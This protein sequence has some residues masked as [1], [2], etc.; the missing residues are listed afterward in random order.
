MKITLET[1]KDHCKQVAHHHFNVV[2]EDVTL[3]PLGAGLGFMSDAYFATISSGPKNI[4]MFVKVPPQDDP[5]K[6]ELWSC[7]EQVQLFDRE[8][9]VYNNL[10]DEFKEFILSAGEDPKRFLDIFPE[11]YSL[12]G[13]MNI[14]RALK[15][16]IVLED[17]GDKGYTM[18]KDDVAGLDLE[19]TFK[20]MEG[21]GKYHGLTMAFLNG[22]GIKDETTKIL[23]DYDMEKM[24]TAGSQDIA[25]KGME[26]FELWL[27]NNN[28]D[29]RNAEKARLLRKDNTWKKMA[30]EIFE[31]KESFPYNVLSHGDCRSNNFMFSYTD[32]SKK[33]LDV[34]FCDHQCGNKI[35]LFYDLSYF[36]LTTPASKD[37]MENYDAIMQKYHSS[38]VDSLTRL[39][40]NKNMPS[41]DE[42]KSILETNF[43]FGY[44]INLVLLFV[45]GYSEEEKNAKCQSLLDLG[46][47]L[48]VFV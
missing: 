4:N 42:I 32:D 2:A 41:L 39:K 6:L 25:N 16:P 8:F 45:N 12:P 28:E 23:F 3:R 1:I 29:N 38:L 47:M 14:E 17:L 40:Y 9:V 20:V 48:K 34:K 22:P 11:S 43:V 46:K 30:L 19:H 37:L 26:L 24:L 44:Y 15:E 18:W 10:L 35:G 13:E 27:E 7:V 31:N 21:L 5:L 33:P 36:I